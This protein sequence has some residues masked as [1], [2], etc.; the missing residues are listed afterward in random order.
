MSC[1]SAANI[2]IE[3]M[4]V[5]FAQV[6]TFCI[7]V[8]AETGTNLGGKYFTFSVPGGT[9]YQPWYD[10]DNASVA[11]GA[12]SGHTLVEVDIVAGDSAA[13][14]AAALIA[15][16]NTLT[17][18]IALADPKNAGRVI[19]KAK[20]YEAVAAPT[21]GTLTGHTVESVSLGFFHDFGYTDGDLEVSTEQQVQDINAHQSGV[22]PITSVINGLNAELSVA[23]K[24][25]SQENLERLIELTSGGAYTPGGGDK[26]IGF[27]S[28][29]NFSNVL[30]RAGRLIL[31]PV[32][33]VD[34][35]NSQDWCLWLAYPK[36][37][38]LVFSGENP[39]LINVTF[40]AYR[41]EFIDSN[42][43]K[44]AYGDHT[45]L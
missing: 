10:K 12:L 43:D 24:E 19:I 33:L 34:S 41:D 13:D 35:D 16:L 38:S 6:P 20:G 9:K 45:Q 3:P 28:G 7:D 37:D 29:Q 22:E 5:W 26:L 42:I 27:G 25:I 21:V 15:E 18:V 11:P 39:E 40:T 8:E 4:K 1:R 2:K 30:D 17:D 14:V 32:R 44:L 23:L 31:H 36:L